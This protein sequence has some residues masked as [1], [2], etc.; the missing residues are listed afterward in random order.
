MRDVGHLPVTQ[1][2]GRSNLLGSE[3][4]VPFEKVV[5]V[6][7]HQVDGVIIVWTRACGDK[8]W[9]KQWN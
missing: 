3:Q 1:R 9:H 5:L 7:G 2:K 8:R 4:A 6:V